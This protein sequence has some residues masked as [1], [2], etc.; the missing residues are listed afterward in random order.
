MKFKQVIASYQISTAPDEITD[1]LRRSQDLAQPVIWQTF[2]DRRSVYDVRTLALDLVKGRVRV[3]YDAD[4]PLIDPKVSVYVKLPFRESVFKGRVL[5]ITRGH[6]D[7]ALPEEMHMREFRDTLRTAFRFGERSAD[8]RPYLAHMR[9]DQL[10]VLKTSLRDVSAKGLGLFVSDA[11]MH[12]FQTGKLMELLALDAVPSPRPL[13]A[14]IV[15]HARHRLRDEALKGLE[16]RIGVK[17]LDPIPEGTL[18]SFMDKKTVAPSP[19][20]HLARQI[21]TPEHQEMLRQE[22]NRTVAKMRQRPAIGKHLAK[23][24]V[25]R[26][27]DDYLPQHIEVLG[28]VCTFLARAMGWVSEASLEK[29]IYVAHLHDAPFF[30]H[31]RLARIKSR[32]EFEARKGQ[33]TEE[34]CQVFLSSPKTAAAMVAADSA[35]PPDADAVMLMQKELPDGTGFPQGLTHGRIPPMAALFI[36][37]HS[38]TDEI[39]ASPDWSLDVWLNSARRQYRGGPFTKILTTLETVKVSLKR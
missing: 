2:P 1:A 8:L 33:L 25:L 34:E 7:L 21:L 19:A 28:V 16:N 36:V 14:Q 6:L 37:A 10:P 22:V 11:N 35:A 13:L 30:D 15:Y 23:L 20:P 9:P 27:N 26:G 38:L 32:A 4:G 31:P 39:M 18:Q 29:F 3:A 17:M 24:E 5:E 12:L